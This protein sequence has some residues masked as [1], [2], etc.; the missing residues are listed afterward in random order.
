MSGPAWNPYEGYHAERPDWG[1][2]WIDRQYKYWLQRAK[3]LEEFVQAIANDE[4]PKCPD[5]D[6]CRSDRGCDQCVA[7]YLLKQEEKKDE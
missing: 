6:M 4:V 1:E 3:T 5:P 2:R 7:Q